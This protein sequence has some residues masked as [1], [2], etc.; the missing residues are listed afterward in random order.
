MPSFQTDRSSG[1][2]SSSYRSFP[3][4]PSPPTNVFYPSG[5]PSASSHSDEHA[6]VTYPRPA[7]QYRSRLHLSHKNSTSSM[8]STFTYAST[9][10]ANTIRGAPHSPHSDIQIIL[11]TPLAPQLQNHMVVSLQQ[12]RLSE[13]SCESCGVLAGQGG[14]SVDRWMAAPSRTTSHRSLRPRP[15]SQ[16][17][18]THSDQIRPPRL[19]PI[20]L[21][22]DKVS[23]GSII[24]E[25]RTSPI[26][27]NPQPHYPILSE[28]SD[29]LIIRGSTHA[30]SPGNDHDSSP[31]TMPRPLRSPDLHHSHDIAILPH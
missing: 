25:L 26:H 27:L 4:P 3:I 20:I 17:G 19:P 31:R 9:R 29:P 2:L 15:P 11:P 16:G 7:S 10:S 18:T 22:M 6:S 1:T 30:P 23:H 5:L 24:E 8:C 28:G 21:T 12:L 13:F 14:T